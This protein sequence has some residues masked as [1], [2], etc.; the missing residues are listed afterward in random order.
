M[1]ALRQHSVVEG[2]CGFQHVTQPLALRILAAGSLA[3]LHACSLRQP[4]ERLR[5]V[6]RVA[7]HDEVE[8]VATPAAAEAL[9][10]LARRRDGERRRLLAVERAQ[11]L[12]R[13]ARLAQLDGLADQLNKVDLLLDF[14]GCAD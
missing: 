14:C 6:D 4:S 3:E 12:V 8:D 2:D 7:L 9:P 13:R 1:V 5:K 10:G 11:S